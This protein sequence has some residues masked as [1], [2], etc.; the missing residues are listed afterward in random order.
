MKCIYLQANT[1]LW[2]PWQGR[3]RL[4]SAACVQSAANMRP[5]RVPGFQRCQRNFR[6][7]SCRS[8]PFFPYITATTALSA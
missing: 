6:S 4:K 5:G 1:D 8:F 3:S 7:F 2:H